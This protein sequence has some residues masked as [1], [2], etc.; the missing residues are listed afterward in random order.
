MHQINETEKISERRRQPLR[1]A[2]DER[3]VWQPSAGRPKRSNA[4]VRS[5]TR[6]LRVVPAPG[7]FA[8]VED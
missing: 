4:T 3:L 1:R 8:F 5:G 7:G 6:R 2:G